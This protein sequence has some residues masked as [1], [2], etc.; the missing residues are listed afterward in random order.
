MI[1]YSTRNQEGTITFFETIEEAI[2]DFCGYLGYRLSISFDNKTLHIHRDDLPK[3]PK[4][5]TF[6][7]PSK[8]YEALII[9]SG[10]WDD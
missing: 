6:F 10:E 3:I 2:N 5:L 1:E 9:L 4:D 7:N 8:H